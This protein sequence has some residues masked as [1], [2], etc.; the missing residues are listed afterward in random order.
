MT[1][2][3]NYIFLTRGNVGKVIS[4]M[5]IPTIAGMLVTS[6]Y[7]LV[8]AYYVGQI[9]TQATAAVGVAFPAM[10]IVQA[11]GFF[12]G[13]G[14]GTFISR[15]LGAKRRNEAE[16]MAST[17]FYLSIITGVALAIVALLF[18][19]PL[20]L[21]FGSTPTILP[22]TKTYLGIM[23]L[24]TPI[25]TATMTLNNQ[26]RFQGNAVSAMVGMM[27]GA[28]LNVAL[29][30][31]FT[32]TFKMGIAGTAIGT[33]L[34]ELVG[35]I[36]LY[37]LAIRGG[38]LRLTLKFITLNKHYMTEMLKGGTPS[39][40]RQGLASVSTM[41]LNLAAASFGD[42]AIAGM[43]IVGRVSFVVFSVV[44]GIG[45]G[46]QPF[47]GFNFGARLFKRVRKGYFYAIKLCLMFLV[48]CCVAGFYFAE[49]VI[50]LMRHDPAVVEVGAAALRWQIITWPLTAFIIMS[51]MALQTSG[52]AISANVV[53]ALRNGLCFIPLIIVLP[54]YWG[55]FGVEVCQTFADV[56]SAAI[57]LPIMV[58]YFRALSKMPS[59][60]NEAPK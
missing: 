20:S 52:W 34:S 1:N 39:L 25:V 44:I 19:E 38:N 37:M 60:V 26:M 14:S 51:N 41:L 50:D 21:A 5:A 31:L 12:F 18:L 59:P 9:N 3:D 4:R 33:I 54:I 47:C 58:R 35:F 46:F 22:Y 13:Q 53:A 24:G 15:Q 32:F 56:I 30:P 8:D 11:I 48:V 17:S 49:E 43:S 29:V 27:T 10:A 23:L 2:K 28:V 6:I 16:R 40:S 36:V 7:N 45:Q 55:I 42:S 57:T